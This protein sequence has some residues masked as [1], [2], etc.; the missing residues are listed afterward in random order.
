[1][2]CKNNGNFQC[3]LIFVDDMCNDIWTGENFNVTNEEMQAIHSLTKIG[4]VKFLANGKLCDENFHRT[5][6]KISK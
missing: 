6:K 1:M 3:I 5:N 2:Y 4:W